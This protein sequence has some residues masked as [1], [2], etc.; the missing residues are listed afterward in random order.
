MR[1]CRQKRWPNSSSIFSRRKL[2]RSSAWK[3][4]VPIVRRRHGAGT[5]AGLG[6]GSTAQDRCFLTGAAW[7]PRS[8]GASPTPWPSSG[9]GN[10]GAVPGWPRAR[11]TGSRQTSRARRA[12]APKTVVAAP[13]QPVQS[14]RDGP[15]RK[16]SQITPP[17]CPAKPCPRGIPGASRRPHETAAP[18]AWSAATTPGKS[19]IQ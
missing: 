8:G 12:R 7:A 10:G 11:E 9:S 16:R 14:G 19:V 4:E 2:S 15:A 6:G 1:R 3:A 13:L 5:L 18:L 17:K